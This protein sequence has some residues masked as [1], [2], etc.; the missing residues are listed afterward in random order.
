[1]SRLKRKSSNFLQ[2]LIAT[3]GISQ[4]LSACGGSGGSNN[5]VPSLLPQLNDQSDTNYVNLPGG[6]ASESLVAEGNNNTRITAGAGDDL[7][8]TF[9]GNDL[10][11]GDAGNDTILSGAGNDEIYGGDGNDTIKPGDGDD[12]IDAGPGDDSIELSAGNDFEDGGDGI[13]TLV[14]SAASLSIPFTINLQTGRYFLTPQSNSQTPNIA[15][16][17]NITSYSSVDL[18][19]SDTIG[20]N[21]IILSSGD[22][23]VTS[24][25]GNDIINT[26]GGN[27]TVTLGLGSYTVDLGG[28]DDILNLGPQ[29]SKINGGS[30]TD[31]VVVSS[32]TG[33]NTVQID[34][35]NDFYF[36]TEVGPSFDGQ[37][38]SLKDFE[39]VTILGGIS[40]TI[41]GG[42][43]ANTILGGAAV[44]NIDGG[45]GDDI[46]SAGDGDDIIDGGAG[47]DTLTGGGGDDTFVFTKS[48]NGTDTITDFVISDDILQ[49]ADSDDLSLVGVSKLNFV[50][51][52]QEAL[53]N[54][55][56]L[57]DATNN[58]IVLT[59]EISDVGAA[60][61][62]IAG[63]SNKI[64]DGVIVIA[65]ATVD[66][67][68]NIIAEFAK[69]WYDA[70]SADNAES[71]TVLLATLNGITLS[72][73]NSFTV[74]N[75]TI[76]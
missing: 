16:I 40:S 47:S 54:G 49:F 42:S 75:F 41:T 35:S 8:Q 18:T 61:K 20:V 2:S 38:I 72:D 73:L 55:I 70:T 14:I 5:L 9:A 28:G 22:D 51:G 37:D 46:I 52:E 17:E 6:S 32:E 53:K 68:P 74:D 4:I 69:I 19:I 62:D 60:V 30:G 15:N 66:D 57:I 59:N 63:T 23:T 67:D 31:T 24:I 48:S 1:M 29:Q 7:I 65:A 27:D 13:D 64:G 3:M 43:D 45:S 39:N 12:T 44:D 76:T 26:G 25:G 34:L 10:I 56:D 50:I 58:V 21:E 36:T 71:D 11:Y 33:L